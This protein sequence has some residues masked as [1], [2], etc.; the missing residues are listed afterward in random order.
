MQYIYNAEILCEPCGEHV[1]AEL[2]AQA[3]D[4]FRERNPDAVID[5]S[6]PEDIAICLGFDPEDGAHDSGEF[7]AAADVRGGESDTPTHCGKCGAFLAGP[8]TEDGMRY[9]IEAIAQGTGNPATLAK[10]YE[11]YLSEREL[12]DVA[13]SPLTDGVIYRLRTFDLYRNDSMGKSMI[14]YIF[15]AVGKPALFWGDDFH[16]APSHST[17]GDD[18]LRSL[19]GFL[20]LRPGDTDQE[21]FDRYTPEQMEFAG[22]YACEVMAASADEDSTEE[23]PDFETVSYVEK[24]AGDRAHYPYL[25]EHNGVEYIDFD[26]LAADDRIRPTFDRNDWAAGDYTYAEDVHTLYL[27]GTG[28]ALYRNR[29]PET[30]NPYFG[31]N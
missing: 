24:L 11:E 13:L 20:T 5:A 27:T 28:Q 9:V 22:T 8:L 3:I 1:I 2:T 16:V 4:S 23:L 12:R 31:G 14:A 21:W 19:L 26:A 17:D 30:Y 6:D 18:C 10:W 29:S 25:V 15:G 7:P